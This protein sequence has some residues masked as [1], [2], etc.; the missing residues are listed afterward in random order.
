ML[1]GKKLN[2]ILFN[3][4]PKCQEGAFFV[5][6]SAFSK[7]FDQMHENCPVCG[8]RYEAEPGFFTGAM[9]VSYALY[10]ATIVSS[11]VLFVVMF[12]MDELNLLWGLI[13]TLIALTPFFFRLARRI[14]INMFIN[15]EPI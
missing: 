8:L 2:S 13:P 11:F 10:V 14:W 6:K 7:R 1:K 9:Y 15:Y 5:T 4:C 3:T 12:G